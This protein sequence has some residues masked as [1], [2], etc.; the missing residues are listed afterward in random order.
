V[1]LRARVALRDVLRLSLHLAAVYRR[2]SAHAIVLLRGDEGGV[3]LAP[4]DVG[5]H[6]GVGA[7]GAQGA[8]SDEGLTRHGGDKQK[9]QGE[10]E[11]EQQ[12]GRGE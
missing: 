8:L 2:G 3:H 12:R 1:S 7:A 9:H 11:G 4:V 10:T 6:E 5:Q